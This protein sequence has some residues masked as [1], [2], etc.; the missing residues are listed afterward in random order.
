MGEVTQ[1]KEQRERVF[2]CVVQR[3]C[4]TQKLLRKKKEDE[5]EQVA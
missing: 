3:A 5:G 1:H 2:I 4:T